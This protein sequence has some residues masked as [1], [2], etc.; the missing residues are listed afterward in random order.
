MHRRQQGFTLIELV[1]VIIILGILAATALPK[2][3]N[4]KDDAQQAAV[5]GVAGALSSAAS[6]N[7]AARSLDSTKG[8]AVA[9]CSDFESALQGGALPSPSNGSYS[10]RDLGASF[11]ATD[12]STATCTVVLKDTGGNV[13]A[14]ATFTAIEVD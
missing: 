3:V 11:P 8:V 12:G 4:F 10:I 13:V 14:S 9:D 5:E 2:F 7:F 6:I 1:I